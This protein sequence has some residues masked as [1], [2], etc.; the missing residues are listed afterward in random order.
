MANTSMIVRDII[1]SLETVIKRS[2]GMTGLCSQVSEDLYVKHEDPDC[3]SI[4]FWRRHRRA[5]FLDW[6]EHS[7]DYDYP[8]P[9]LDVE[10]DA[11]ETYNATMGMFRGQYGKLRVELAKSTIISL[12]GILGSCK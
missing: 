10:F 12:Q 3:V 4:L 11:R 6:A 5:L 1:D 9:S 7:G 2:E 8:V